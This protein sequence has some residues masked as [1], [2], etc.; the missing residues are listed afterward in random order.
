M[1]EERVNELL[2]HLAMGREPDRE[3]AR[4]RRQGFGSTNPRLDRTAHAAASDHEIATALEMV[5]RARRALG[6]SLESLVVLELA[7]FERETRDIVER[8]NAV[9]VDERIHSRNRSKSIVSVAELE[10]GELPSSAVARPARASDLTEAERATGID[11]QQ[12]SAELSSLRVLQVDSEGDVPSGAYA[13]WRSTDDRYR[14]ALQFGSAQSLSQFRSEMDA[15]GRNEQGILPPALRR[16][17]FDSIDHIG[18]VAREDRIGP[19]LASEGYPK[20]VARAA[21]D[22]DL[23]HPGTEEGAREALQQLRQACRQKG[24]LVKDELCT[25]SLVL[26]RVDATPALTDALLEL[27]IVARVDLPPVIDAAQDVFRDLGDVLSVPLPSGDEPRVAVIDSG[28][29]SAHPLLRGWV[30]DEEDFGTSEGTASD[31]QGHGT[32]V[33]GLV[34]YGDIAN[35]LETNLWE[36]SVL[37]C[38]A[39]VLEKDPVSGHPVF[40][41]NSRPERLVAKAIQHFHRERNCR[42]F[43]LSIGNSVDVYG[44]GARQF[45]WAE[46]LD[47]LARDLNIVIVVSAGNASKPCLPDDPESE[48]ELQDGVRHLLLEN[49]SNRII[50]PATAA[51]AVTVGSIARS[52]TPSMRPAFAGAPKGGPSPFTRVGPGYQPKDTQMGVKPEFVAFGGNSAWR[53]ALGQANWRQDPALGEPTLRHEYS[54]RLVT[55]VEGTSF[56]TPHVSSV[57]AHAFEVAE[58]LLGQAPTANTVR[59][60]LGAVSVDPPGGREWL[61]DPNRQESLEKLRLTGY[62]SLSFDRVH[63]SLE[64]DAVLLAEDQVQLDHWHL[65]RLPVPPTFLS[66][67]GARGIT[68]A[69]AF[70]PPVR[71]SRREYLANTMFLEVLKELSADQVE[72]FRALP[73]TDENGRRVQAP[74]MPS[75]HDLGMRPSKE[76]LQWSTLQVRKKV[77]SSTPRLSEVLGEVYPVLHVLVGAQRRFDTNEDPRQRYS[78][79]IRLWHENGAARIYE[80]LREH[81]RIRPQ[82]RVRAQIRN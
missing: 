70:D 39:K 43:N 59:A 63:S 42:V 81:V 68:A 66:T 25:R 18:V 7:T 37:I 52:A 62:G 53:A 57:A 5:T 17:F 65:F 47:E 19:R 72:L 55:A 49:A 30:V 29:L 14:V 78:L 61:L 44:A 71:A 46:V 64:H 82:T 16:N 56:A 38:S 75:R 48:F 2:M 10:A 35:C 54:E 9:V 8:F 28:V 80:F 31:Q 51:L 40:P 20:G 74:Q 73:G 27:D 11:L 45:A 67:P 32:Q 36:P 13:T 41:T 50:N 6:V 60:L 22:I 76:R 79:A 24:G 26:V 21:L 34:A 77:W 4:R 12:L 58:K 33:A 69:L 3:P 23:W 15:Y 1:T